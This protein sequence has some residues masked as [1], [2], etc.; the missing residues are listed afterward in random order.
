MS[1]YGYIRVNTREQNENRQVTYEP[2]H[3]TKE[4][5]LDR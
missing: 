2:Q 5:G 3:R 1:V 4:N